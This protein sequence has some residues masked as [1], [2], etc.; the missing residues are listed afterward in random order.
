ML[1]H[2]TV[3]NQTINNIK[4]GD[5]NITG[6]I[7]IANAINNYWAEIG[8]KLASVIPPTDIDPTKL[9]QPCSSELNLRTITTTELRAKVH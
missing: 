2:K 5:Q 7:N 9:I 1:N 3:K 4:L 8:P 6:D